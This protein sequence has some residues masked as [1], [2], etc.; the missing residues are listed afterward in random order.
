MKNVSKNVL[1]NNVQL[2]KQAINT[3]KK[4]I[5]AGYYE[6]PPDGRFRVTAW[7]SQGT[8]F[9]NWILPGFT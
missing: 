1:N 2:I 7:G 3:E 9:H 5:A 4:T 8:F 6:Y